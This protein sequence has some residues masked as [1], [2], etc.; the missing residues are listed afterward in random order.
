M[1]SIEMNRVEGDL[2]LNLAFDGNRVS[3]AWT[4]GTMYR[5]FEQILLGRA[6]TDGLV[7]TPRICGICGTGH[8]YAAV[9]ALE[10]AMQCAVAPNG[11]RV[12]NVC[13]LAEEIQSDI[14][15][16]FLMFC[17]DFCNERYRLVPGFDGIVEAFEPFKGQVYRETIVQTKK[18]LEIVALF[19]GQ[20]PHSSYMVPGGVVS[21]P[22]RRTI[23]AALSIVDGFVRWYERSVLGCSTERWLEVRS[24]SDLDTWLNESPAH[25]TSALGRFVQFARALHLEALGKGSGR[26]LSY[27]V[28]LDPDRWQ[29]PF[30]NVSWARAAGFYD[31][32]IGSIQTF[33]HLGVKEHVR[34]SYFRD[35][36]GGKHPWDGVTV[37]DYKPG[38]DKYS[39]AKAP[40]YDDKVVEV[41]CVAEL[42]MARDALVTSMVTELGTNVFTR[43]LARLHRPA[44]SLQLI[45]SVLVELEAHFDDGYC[46]TPADVDE[47]RGHGLVH[48][49]RGA[50][51]HWVTIKSGRIEGYQVVTPTAWN[52][53]PRDS[54]GTP[55][56]WEQ[57]LVGTEVANVDDPIEI[58]HIVRSHD[59]CLVCTVHHL[60]TRKRWTFPV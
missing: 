27:G 8:L 51:G 47:G 54:S 4:V 7:I 18:I 15:H 43:Q 48:A 39:W 37:P 23:A 55:G 49:A 26:M 38:G 6:K 31:P 5:G 32:D 16:A 14:R 41:G 57:S 21:L 12:R 50:L 2:Q 34:H 33:S 36:A 10:T 40:R 20:W 28:Y 42:F 30:D 35:Y 45:R 44:L 56:H 52:A 46:E 3:E 11:T 60:E 24:L 19:G 53:S 13:L 59:A 22:S 25:A 1:V 9:T 17:I 58:G 29:P